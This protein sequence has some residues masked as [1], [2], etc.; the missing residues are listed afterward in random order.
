MTVKPSPMG[1][2]SYKR[3]TTE[4]LLP[5][6]D[7]VKSWSLLDSESITAL[8]LDFQLPKC[9]L[10]IRHLS[11]VFCYSSPNELRH[12]IFG[13]QMKTY[14]ILIA[15]KAMRLWA[16]SNNTLLFDSFSAE[17]RQKN[18]DRKFK[19]RNCLAYLFLILE[20]LP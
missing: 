19:R 17:K 11:R 9:L 8:I 18:R 4:P 3:H 13:T 12:Y 2:C 6:E 1:Y 20:V 10:F 14:L 15:R 7:T 5:H 16:S